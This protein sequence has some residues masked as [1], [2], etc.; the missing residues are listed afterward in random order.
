MYLQEIAAPKTESAILPTVANPVNV[1]TL[2][3]EAPETPE[4]NT[5]STAVNT[6]TPLP[7]PP[8]PAFVPGGKRM[9]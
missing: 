6:P 7:P 4:T 2:L 3:G 1:N 5:G 9:N 8:M